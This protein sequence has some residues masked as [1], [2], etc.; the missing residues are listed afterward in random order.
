MLKWSLS[1]VRRIID[2]FHKG[3]VNPMANSDPAKYAKIVR[4]AGKKITA[5]KASSLEFLIKAGI[6]DHSGKLRP[7]YKES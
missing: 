4:D 3:K 1:P 5:S 2:P 7:E 6:V